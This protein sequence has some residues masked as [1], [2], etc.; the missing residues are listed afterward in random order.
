MRSLYLPTRQG[1]ALFL[2]AYWYHQ[3]DSFAEP[4]VWRVWRDRLSY[5]PSLLTFAMEGGSRS[6]PHP[7]TPTPL[8]L[9]ALVAAGKLNVAVNYWYQGHSLATRL[10][11]TFRENLF[12]NCTFPVTPGQ[13]H[14]CRDSL[15]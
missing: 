6:P 8:P 7:P 15:L 4:G 14:I 3:V 13:A 10:Y 1:D 5:H 9:S 12:I 11:R 2:P